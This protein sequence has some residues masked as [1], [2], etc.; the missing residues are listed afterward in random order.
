MTDQKSAVLRAVV[1]AAVLRSAPGV[2]DAQAADISRR[3]IAVDLPE[4]T[5]DGDIRLASGEPLVDA[6]A[7][8]AQAAPH[9]FTPAEPTAQADAAAASRAKLAAMK[10]GARLEAANN[11]GVTGTWVND[12][13]KGRGQ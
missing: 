2:S 6:L 9:L 5:G 7:R 10:A 13:R 8:H 1:R 4:I 12:F 11:A 3:V